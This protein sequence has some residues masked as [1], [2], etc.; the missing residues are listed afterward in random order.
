MVWRYGVDA[1]YFIVMINFHLRRN[2]LV[3]VF[4]IV[5]IGVVWLF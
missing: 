5:P 2:L 3:A 4:I 1:T